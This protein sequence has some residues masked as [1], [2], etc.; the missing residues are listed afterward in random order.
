V[1]LDP[2]EAEVLGWLLDDSETPKT[3][4]G[5][6]CREF[7]TSASTESVCAAL[8]RLVASGLVQAFEFDQRS[9]AFRPIVFPDLPLSAW[10]MATRAG[11]ALADNSS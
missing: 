1:N 2:L 9:N 8:A 10:F 3:L 5:E 7:G 6:V 4:A 11:R